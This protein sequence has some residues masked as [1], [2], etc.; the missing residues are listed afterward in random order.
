MNKLAVITTHPIQYNAP[1]FKLLAERG[2]IEVKVFYTWGESAVN[3]YDPGFGKHIEWDIP[4]LN[5]Y[6]FCFVKNIAAVSGSNSFKG[7]DNPTLIDEI[8][9]WKADAVLVYG[10]S[11]KSHIKAIRYFHKKIPVIFRGDSTTLNEKKGLKKIVRT[12]FLKWV[13]SYVDY[14]LYVGVHNKLYFKRHGL[15]EHQLVLAHHAV[16]N[17]RFAQPDGEYKEAAKMWRHQ[18]G[19]KAHELTI[20][21]A[22][23]FEDIKNPSCLVKLS[24]KMADLPVK[25]I[26]VGNGHLEKELKTSS[27]DCSNILFLDFQNQL[28]MPVVYR[29]CDL[30]IL[31]SKS[32]T[33]GLSVNEA[34]ACGKGILVSDKCGCA[35]DLVT[36]DENGYIFNI[37]QIDDLVVGI[38][39]LLDHRERVKIM[40]LASSRKI[41]NFSFVNTVRA[42]EMT[43][44]NIL[45]SKAHS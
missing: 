44:I 24:K 30:F 21:Y 22:G 1:L 39:S 27:R 8:V 3:K 34:M 33:W 26:L 10:W 6:S 41:E 40:G 7:I 38:K 42:I 31:P 23:K 29:L 17:N 9:N 15:K 36:N 4:L 37:E 16:D 14:A 32:E 35:A 45:S 19:V 5:G 25:F 28:T 2:R 18:L 20:L 13:Y 43:I 12:L 11:F